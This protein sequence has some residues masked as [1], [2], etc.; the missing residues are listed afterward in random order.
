MFMYNIRW[1]S[2]ITL[3]RSLTAI[4]INII[5]MHAKTLIKEIDKYVL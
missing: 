4:I 3:C 1:C 5:I 2:M